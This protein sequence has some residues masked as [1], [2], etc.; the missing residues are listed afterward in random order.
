MGLVSVAAYSGYDAQAVTPA[1]PA[2]AS[3]PLAHT[4][5]SAQIKAST[6]P[7]AAR[8]NG[9]LILADDVGWSDLG[10]FGSEIRT[11]NLDALASG[12]LSFTQFYNSAR[13]SPT[14]ASLR[15][16]LTPHQSGV[17]NIGPP[18]SKRAVTLAEVLGTAGYSTSMVGKWHLPERNTPVDRGFGEFYG[19]PG[20]FNSYFKENPAFTRLPAD[21][22]RRQY[23]PEQ[24]YSTD[25]LAD[26]WNTKVTAWCARAIGNWW[27]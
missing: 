21:H 7:Q 23:A 25:A 17:V 6:A 18:L 19:M 10:C 12:G 14:R 24:F 5:S 9:L 11:P 2:A 22:P 16:G 1:E 13:C 4:R 8:P 26:I 20:G 3:S 15:T 27:L